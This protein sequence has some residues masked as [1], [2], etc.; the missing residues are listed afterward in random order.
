MV[1]QM[2]FLFSLGALHSRRAEAGFLLIG[3]PVIVLASVTIT[4]P[5]SAQTRCPCISCTVSLSHRVSFP[6]GSDSL[7]GHREMPQANLTL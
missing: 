3:V 4:K 6:S 7:E 5:L 2:T 1:F